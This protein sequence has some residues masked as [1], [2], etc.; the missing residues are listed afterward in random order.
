M[1]MSNLSADAF[2]GFNYATAP[3][4][5]KTTKVAAKAK[6]ISQQGYKAK[7]IQP[8]GAVVAPPVNT[9]GGGV[10]LPN[11]NLNF[12][13]GAVGG[14]L[15]NTNTG[16]S[17]G[18][19]GGGTLPNPNLNFGGGSQTNTSSGSGSGTSGGGFIV[20][21][22][23]LID[24]A[25]IN[26][27]VGQNSGLIPIITPTTNPITAITTDGIIRTPLTTVP[28]V[29]IAP[30]I[31][32]G[33][34]VGGGYGGGGYGGGGDGGGVGAV[35]EDEP[36]LP[37]PQIESELIGDKVNLNPDDL[38]FKKEEVANV[39]SSVKS[40]KSD[41]I[42]TNDMLLVFGLFVVTISVIG[43]IKSNKKSK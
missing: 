1:S 13:G 22:Q 37:E 36:Q 24:N 26:P 11:P 23:G 29:I 21:N 16:S 5:F 9:G 12:G 34:Y 19:V 40:D 8:F 2:D 4:P 30:I 17:S 42:T 38:L 10:T 3:K 14:S 28:P 15:T 41:K 39:S 20:K 7:P 25:I 32:G 27:N 43:I 6:P 18:T 33:D 31:G 35:Y